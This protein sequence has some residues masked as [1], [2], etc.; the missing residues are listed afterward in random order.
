[1]APRAK[2][3]HQQSAA[4]PPT[5]DIG[6]QGTVN[7][8]DD[9]LFDATCAT[10][11]MSPQQDM[12]D[13]EDTEMEYL[14]ESED[15]EDEEPAAKRNRLELIVQKHQTVKSIMNCISMLENLKK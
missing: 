8:D 6:A 14:Q 11:P 4:P 13:M 3:D 9:E 7:R 1:M 2:E 15:S 12:K 10:P 5:A